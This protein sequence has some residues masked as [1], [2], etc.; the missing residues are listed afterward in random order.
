MATF[1]L[2]ECV[3]MIDEKGQRTETVT[4]KEASLLRDGK[5]QGFLDREHHYHARRKATADNRSFQ[6]HL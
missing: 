3:R 6:A 2:K 4:Y 5:T 1:V